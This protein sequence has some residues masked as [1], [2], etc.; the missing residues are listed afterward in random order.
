LQEGWDCSFAYIL[1]IL[2]NPK[3]KNALTQ[4]V[5]RIL[6]QPNA[7]KTKVKLL[8]EC[9]VYCFQQ[10]AGGLMNA[11]RAGL[12]GEGLGDIAGRVAENTDDT[13]NE[14]QEEYGYRKQFKKFEGKLYLPHFIIQEEGSWRELRYEMD[15]ASRIDWSQA[16]VS[17]IA[18]LHLEALEAKDEHVAFKLSSDTAQMVEKEK[19][20]RLDGGH[21]KVDMLF[22]TRHILE[23]MPNPWVAYKV[24]TEAIDGLRKK[25]S[26]E[27]IAANLV[28]I[29]EA[30]VDV[31]Q[32]QKDAQAEHV[33][34]KLI[35]EKKVCFFL[36][37]GTG[38]EIPKSIRVTTSNIFMDVKGGKLIQKSL[39]EKTDTDDMNE[40]EQAVAICLDEQDKL[41]FW[42]RNMTHSGYSVQGWKKNRAYPDF[43]MA[44]KTEEDPTDYSKV[45]V[46]ETKGNHLDNPDTRYKQSIFEICNEFGKQTPWGELE[47]EFS[48]KEV[49]FQ[50]VFEDEWKQRVL[51]EFR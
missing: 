40:F 1:T 46:I 23:V 51:E 41:L 17:S 24:A 25:N 22:I 11:I 33:F 12:Q 37:K 14:P 6:R 39:F 5:G 35:K 13:V 27:L 4:L 20:E 8:D 21:L 34:K 47:L 44:K 30:L 2:T 36:Q 49:E 15:L 31:L 18:G 19:A 50:V 9:Y 32:K 38:F 16:D 48:H 10:N 29:V 3:S 43:I 7:R 26:E 42:Y 28:Y 45:V